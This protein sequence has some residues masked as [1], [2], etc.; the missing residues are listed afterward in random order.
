MYRR[1]NVMDITSF[2]SQPLRIGNQYS[3]NRL[4]LAPMAGL[5]HIA[6]RELLAEFGGHG[7]MFT[8]MCSARAVPHENR[9]L[10]PVF[11]WRDEEL[12]YLVCQIF[13]SEP[14]IMA[15]AAVRI[16]NEGF[17]GVDINCGCAVSA[18]CKKK[19]GAAL[20]KNPQRAEAIV[21]AIRRAV[22]IPVFVKY[23]TGW[24]DD[25]EFAVECAKR[26]EAAGADALIFHPRV[27]PD[28]RSRP[29]KWGYIGM[30]K[31]AVSI[32]VFG[33]GNVCTLEDCS[34]M[35]DLTGCDG[36]AV[37]RMAI[38]RPWLFKTWLEKK[39][40]A[41][42]VYYRSAL[43][44]VDLLEAYNEPKQAVTLF[45]KFAIY[46]SAN[47]RFGHALYKQFN[48]ATDL[49]KIRET[50]QKMI[51]NPPEITATPNMNLFHN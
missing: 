36:I 24:A 20:L 40:P 38:A 19:C 13:G 2:L 18:I 44:M 26:F 15:E 9:Y 41:D 37:G 43:R 34:K 21:A 33:N 3:K 29:P 46:F 11:R 30:V 28:R 6:Y 48:Q 4:L 17:W 45:K 50:I 42:D 8:G 7:L 16:E 32:P 12:T 27:A 31:H 47:F 35:I 39:P 22:S 23:R 25:P 49:I 1:S 51:H 5:G 14:R 10:S